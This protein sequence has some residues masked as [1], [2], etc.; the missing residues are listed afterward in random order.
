MKRTD[1]FILSPVLVLISCIPSDGTTVVLNLTRQNI[2]V[3]ADSLWSRSD[4]KSEAPQTF[5]CK[6]AN[7]GNMYY[8]A[9]A[10]D[11]DAVLLESF[12][13]QAMM[14]SV[15]L[16]EAADKLSLTR[17]TLA[18]HTARYFSQDTI[19]QVWNNGKEA[20]SVIIFGI[21]HGEPR[22]ILINFVQVGHSRTK[23][24]FETKQRL[25]PVECMN[26]RPILLGIHEHI[27]TALKKDPDM[28]R[29]SGTQAAVRGL[30]K[31]EEDAVPEFVGGPIDVLTLDRNGLHWEATEGGTCSPEETRLPTKPQALSQLCARLPKSADEHFQMALAA[32]DFRQDLFDSPECRT[33]TINI[34][35]DKRDAQLDCH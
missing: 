5:G 2:V 23:L 22:L 24:K 12:A 17:D 7:V 9:S 31:L 35:M 13:K 25:C 1:I 21:E 32:N 18:E 15:T 29:G 16:T 10:S 4:G 19:D 34:K 28:I 30:V 6:I 26:D 14:T 3:A 27:D 20:A 11:I 8:T 33:N